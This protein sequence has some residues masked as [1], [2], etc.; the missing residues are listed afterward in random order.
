M[1]IAYNRATSWLYLHPFVANPLVD[2]E[3]SYLLQTCH[4]D[5]PITAEL[6][7]GSG[8]GNN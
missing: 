4:T 5:I 1:T 6:R 2:G 8:Q 3:F 7:A